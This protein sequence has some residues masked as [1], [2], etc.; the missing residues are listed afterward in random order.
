[1]GEPAFHSVL[2]LG[3]R[4]VGVRNEPRRL[5]LEFGKS[6]IVAFVLVLI[7]LS[8]MCVIA[9]AA[10]ASA[11]IPV[12]FALV[13]MGGTFVLALRTVNRSPVVVVT[14]TAEGTNR[15]TWLMIA[16]S[17]LT[18][19]AAALLWDPVLIP[20]LVLMGIMAL[21]VWRGRGRIPE[22]LRA[23]RRLLAENESVLGGGMGLDRAQR[24]WRDG[25]RLAVATDAASF[26][27]DPPLT[28]PFPLVD[29]PYPRVSRFGI[30][31][32]Q[33][34][35]I[36]VLSLTV[37]G[38]D[39]APPETLEIT[40]IGPANLVSLARA[41][42]SHGVQADD[43]VAIADAERGW[44]EARAGVRPRAR[45]FDPAAMST[46]QFDHGLWLLPVVGALC[47]VCGYV[48]GTRSSLA[49]I[50]PLNLLA[51]P[52]FLFADADGVVIL[53]VVMSLLAA[54][55]LWAGSASCWRWCWR[56]S[57]PLPPPA[58]S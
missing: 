22:V 24:N 3:L 53:M 20:G 34:G 17:V 47:A 8:A 21:V 13:L 16:P 1:M 57:P 33:W 38:L 43:P 29:V 51:T 35:R 25:F 37:D 39:G 58:S 45:L 44:E 50:A 19:V 36:G 11:L 42:E 48:S 2:D 4:D 23:F 12:V 52:T 54:L 5:A 10:G 18:V 46:R 41:L 55:G 26:W 30:R 15:A 40:S 28:Q 9:G 49:Y 7:S 32:K 27:P 6:S 56:A 14:V 31:W